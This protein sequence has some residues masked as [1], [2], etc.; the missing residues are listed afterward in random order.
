MK[1]LLHSKDQRIST[2]RTVLAGAVKLFTLMGLGFA[3][4]PF[5]KF[6]IPRIDEDPGIEIDVSGLG[7]NESMFVDWLGR[8]IVVL[9]RSKEVLSK[10]QQTIDGMLQDPNSKASRQPGFALNP[11]RSLRPEYLVAYTNCT[12]LGCEIA[13]NQG[14]PES[15]I[16]FECP[17]HKSSYDYSGRVLSGQA[18][19]YNLEIPDYTF[20]SGRIIRLREKKGT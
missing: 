15:S 19:P 13:V 18:A 6:L 4:V 16:G 17:C 2:R 14:T 1:K 20:V 5:I 8:R 3:G 11:Y 9:H 7:L 10:L 12:H